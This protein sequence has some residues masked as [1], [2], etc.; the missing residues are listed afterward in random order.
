[1]EGMKRIFSL[2]TTIIASANLEVQPAQKGEF[3]GEKGDFLA[4]FCT[5]F[6]QFFSKK[7]LLGVL[8]G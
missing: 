1:L 7:H 6:G 3:W 4:R 5:Y 2:Q 8:F